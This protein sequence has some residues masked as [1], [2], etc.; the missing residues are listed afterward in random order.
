MNNKHRF[1]YCWKISDGYPA[2][3]IPRHSLNV[4]GTFICGGGSTMGY[5]LAGYNHLGG[6]EIDKQMA[7]IYQTNHQPKYLFLEDIRKFVN[8]NDIPKELYSLDILDGSPPC[9]TFS[10][11]GDRQKSWGKKK[12][13]RE[14]QDEQRLDDLFF[15][16]IALAAKLKPKVVIAENVK[17]LILGGAKAYVAKIF[18][19]FDSAGYNVQL[20]LLNAASMGVPQKRER[21]FFIARRKDLKLPKLELNFN[22]DP[23]TFGMIEEK[24]VVPIPPEDALIPLLPYLKYGDSNFSKACEKLKGKGNFFGNQIIYRNRVLNTIDTKASV[25]FYDGRRRI[26]VKELV[27]CGTFPIDYN[28]NGAPARYVIGMSVPPVMTAQVSY[29]IYLQWLK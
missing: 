15:T 2:K 25:Y 24:S 28:F 10:M 4:F 3:E 27:S 21:V 12:V 20:F 29:Q 14:G 16:Y 17:G 19:E 7:E 6:V 22:E 26:D 1:P 13:F 8:R 18:K 9:S 5:K 11:N 23:I